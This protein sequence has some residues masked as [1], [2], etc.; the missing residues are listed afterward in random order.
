[1]WDVTVVEKT[2]GRA[3]GVTFLASETLR[4]GCCVVGSEADQVADRSSTG[5]HRSSGKARE[6]TVPDSQ[7]DQEADSD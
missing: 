3:G 1:M 6:A 2:T 7:S 4:A 5:V